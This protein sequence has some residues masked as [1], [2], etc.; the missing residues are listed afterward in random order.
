M[1]LLTLRGDFGDGTLVMQTQNPTNGTYYEAGSASWT[2]EAEADI[3]PDG[4]VVRFVLTGATD[5]EIAVALLP[6]Q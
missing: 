5:P 4:K 2:G 1:Y 3:R 6:H